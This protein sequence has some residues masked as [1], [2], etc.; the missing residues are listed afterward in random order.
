MLDHDEFDEEP[1][2][3]VF[4]DVL[5]LALIGF[6]A[7]VI[8]LLPHLSEKR[9]EA[10][11]TLAERLAGGCGSVGAGAWRR[12]GGLLEPGQPLFQPAA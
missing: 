9:D 3:T 8:M 2:G 1:I 10:K 5:M 7:M 11:D 6:V 12:A 4:R